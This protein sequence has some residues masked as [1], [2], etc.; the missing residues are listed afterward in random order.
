MAQAQDCPKVIALSAIRDSAIDLCKRTSVWTQTHSPIYLY[1]NGV[2]YKMDDTPRDAI[3]D[4]LL[5]AKV[6]GNNID[7]VF[8][9]ELFK[10]QGRKGRPLMCTV[11]TPGTVSVAPVPAERH[12][13][14]LRV[15][16]RPKKSATS[17]DDL[18]LDE[19]H[20][21]IVYGALYR[22]KMMAEKPWSDNPG[23]SSNK[24]LFDEGVR[25]AKVKAVSGYG[26]GTNSLHQRSFG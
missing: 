14:V 26:A 7:V 15:A 18:V 17:M 12:E 19:W 21:I 8:P 22:L 13:M 9:R 6:D 24:V 11:S 20:Q 23:A 16:L 5:D 10:L 2:E 3:V 4:R 1:N 25:K